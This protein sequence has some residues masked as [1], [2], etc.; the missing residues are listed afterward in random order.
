MQG[1]SM[2]KKNDKEQ[3]KNCI[4]KQCR[5][6]QPEVYLECI[7]CHWCIGN[8]GYVEVCS[9]CIIKNDKPRH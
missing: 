5:K 1:D 6:N 3:C 9:K 7:A 4:C 8:D 2:D